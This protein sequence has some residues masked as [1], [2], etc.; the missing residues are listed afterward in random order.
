MLAILDY[1][2][3]N[4]FSVQNAC[5]HL[6]IPATITNDIALLRASDA[7]IL[8][9]VGAFKDAMQSLES[10]GLIPLIRA[11]VQEGK[12]LLG[13]CL[14]MQLLYEMSVEHG[15]YPGLGLINGKVMDM[16]IACPQELKIPHMG[17]NSLNFTK[18]SELTKNRKNGDAVYFVHSYYV[19]S[20]GSEVLATAEY[21]VTVPAI[22]QQGN[23]YGMQ[24]HPEKSGEIGLSLLDAFYELVMKQKE[25]GRKNDSLS[26]N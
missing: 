4:L 1:G 2:V 13:I 26:S 20:D 15:E 25:G 8:P 14:G 5:D 17:W 12:P 3:G 10:S 16:K 6:G 21:G 22:I 19:V 23:I 24:F 9:G 18:Q 11:L 7:I